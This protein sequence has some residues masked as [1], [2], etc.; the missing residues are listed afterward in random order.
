MNGSESFAGNISSGIAQPVLSS[1]VGDVYNLSLPELNIPTLEATGLPMT[2]PVPSKKS[3]SISSR[4]PS[5]I[6]TS[7]QGAGIS[8]ATPTA[9]RQVEK[10][11]ELFGFT[12]ATVSSSEGTNSTSLQTSFISKKEKNIAE[13][14]QA[15]F[16][17]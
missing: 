10:G 15:I 5:P 6:N 9:Q 7:R 4:T 14:G 16:G 12:P 8:F 11:V 3:S 1:P 2:T 17:I 13:Q